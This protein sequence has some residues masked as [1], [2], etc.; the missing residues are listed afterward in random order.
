MG[1]LASIAAIVL[2]LP[3]AIARGQP[4]MSVQ[5]DRDRIYEGDSVVYTVILHNVP[6]P[7]RPEITE[8]DEYDVKFLE[9]SS[10]QSI[11][12][13]G[14]GRRTVLS[15]HGVSLLA[16]A[17]TRRRAADSAAHRPGGWQATSR[18]NRDAA[19]AGA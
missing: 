10:R 8:S 17:K 6:D 4:Q 13:D 3:T 11:E 19:S 14:L 1:K 2:A 9:E 7:Q 18:P 15:L 5:L 12:L 16:H